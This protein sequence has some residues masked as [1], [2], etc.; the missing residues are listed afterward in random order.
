MLPL[1][2]TF[3]SHS[4]SRRHRSSPSLRLIASEHCLN[5]TH[6]TSCSSWPSGLVCVGSVH[7]HCISQGHYH[8]S[9][10]VPAR[11]HSVRWLPKTK[12]K[13]SNLVASAVIGDRDWVQYST[14]QYKGRV[15]LTTGTHGRT[16]ENFSHSPA[17][18]LVFIQAIA[19]E[20]CC[21]RHCP[22][23]MVGSYI[24]INTGAHMPA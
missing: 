10:P 20:Y 13:R 4:P 24:Y 1:T 6:E 8:Y 16:E 14:V 9:V 17:P 21:G 5:L 11:T 2:I 23:N 19:T 7:Q 3:L 22:A 18:Q 12:T 15:T